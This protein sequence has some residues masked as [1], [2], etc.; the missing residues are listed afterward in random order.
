MVVVGRRDRGS[1]GERPLS[2]H[3]HGKGQTI[4]YNGELHAKTGLF[5]T[6]TAMVFW[7]KRNCRIYTR[8]YR[9][10][11]FVWF[12]YR[13][14]HGRVCG[15]QVTRPKD[16]WNNAAKKIITPKI[17]ETTT[18]TNTKSSATRRLTEDESGQLVDGVSLFVNDPTTTHGNT[19][20]VHNA[21]RAASRFVWESVCVYKQATNTIDAPSV[22]QA[23]TISRSPSR[24]P[25]PNIRRSD[26][27]P[28]TILPSSA[29]PGGSNENI[30]KTRTRGYVLLLLLLRRSC[31]LYCGILFHIHRVCSKSD[32]CPAINGQKKKNRKKLFFLLPLRPT[33]GRNANPLIHLH[34]EMQI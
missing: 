10:R 22:R 19:S 5:P 2:R 13:V 9:H 26:L 32:V 20:R 27:P 7:Q 8:A 23:Q 24:Y 34:Y 3:K 29:G 21:H 31:V 6:Y 4:V 18:K 25:R 1:T 15:A 12:T 16:G 14:T 33:N 28:P 30:K 11:R 17:T